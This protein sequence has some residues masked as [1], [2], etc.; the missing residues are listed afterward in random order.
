MAN[1]EKSEYQIKY[2]RKN[3][4]GHV[5]ICPLPPEDFFA[6]GPPEGTKITQIN[7]EVNSYAEVSSQDNNEKAIKRVA[8]LAVIELLDTVPD[9]GIKKFKIDCQ[10]V[11]PELGQTIF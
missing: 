6:G 5:W 11:E 2:G 8:Q 10:M 1:Y 4:L 3:G 7:N 9:I